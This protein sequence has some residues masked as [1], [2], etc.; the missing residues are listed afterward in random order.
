MVQCGAFGRL[1][2]SRSTVTPSET[3][4]PKALVPAAIAPVPL[5][6]VPAPAAE[7]RV[8][9]PSR[10]NGLGV[11]PGPWRFEMARAV[12]AAAVDTTQFEA[13]LDFTTVRPALPWVRLKVSIEVAFLIL[14]SR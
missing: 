3:R 10:L 14:V 12:A 5:M 2:P 11:K 8:Q 1:L 7:A 6:L 4:P 13:A 9:T